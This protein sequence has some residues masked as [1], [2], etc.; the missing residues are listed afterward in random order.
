MKRT[1]GRQEKP[2]EEKRKLLPTYKDSSSLYKQLTANKT[3]GTDRMC[4]RRKRHFDVSDNRQREEKLLELIIGNDREKYSEEYR[5][6]YLSA[7]IS[8]FGPMRNVISKR[9]HSGPQK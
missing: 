5:F 1:K 9:Q 3:K 2:Q 7:N 8:Y 4:F 6:I